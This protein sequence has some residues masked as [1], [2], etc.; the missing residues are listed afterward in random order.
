MTTS[1]GL[2]LSRHPPAEQFDL[3]RRAEALGFDSVWTG[4]HLSFHNPLYESLTLLVIGTPADCAEQLERFRAA[5]GDDFVLNPVAEPAEER[6]QLELMATE[7]LP[8]F[9]ST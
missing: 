1:F 7:L 4:D 2:M 6:E 8:R 9:R 3:V 5:G